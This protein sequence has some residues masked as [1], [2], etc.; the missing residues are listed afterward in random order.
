MAEFNKGKILLDFRDARRESI[1][2][3][4]TLTFDNFHVKSLNFRITLADFPRRVELAA[5][6]TGNWTVHIQP[7]HYRAKS[8]FIFLP[9]G[10]E[11]TAREFFFI[12]PA[13][14]KP[15]F[16]PA[17]RVF[18][19]DAW[20]PLADLLKKSL[21]GGLRG[22]DLYK[23][24]TKKGPLKAAGLLNLHARARAVKWPSGGEVFAGFDALTDIRQERFYAAVG[25]EF[26]DEVK[27]SVKAKIFKPASGLLHPFPEGFERLKK[28][29]SFKTPED[30]GNLQLTFAQND[31]EELWVD[32]DMD[33][34]MGI[35]HAFEVLRHVFTGAKTHPYDIHQILTFFYEDIDPGYTLRPV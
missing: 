35:K 23:Q 30:A 34:A 22:S 13:H 3:P 18:A 28:D 27:R 7:D 26:H 32:V 17:N 31:A 9:S 29:A 6:P 1:A 33:E 8:I 21:I 2:S 16:P 5:F 15:T 20:K 19:E 4:M 14:A 11:L 12:S 24:L 10:A 25:K